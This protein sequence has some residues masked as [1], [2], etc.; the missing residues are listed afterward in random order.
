[1]EIILRKLLLKNLLKFDILSTTDDAIVET[2]DNKGKQEDMPFQL[3]HTHTPGFPI[4]N[5]KQKSVRNDIQTTRTLP[6]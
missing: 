2:V 4:M 1:M 3:I 6:L 5:T